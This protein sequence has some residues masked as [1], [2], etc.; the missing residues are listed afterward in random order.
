MERLFPDRIDGMLGLL[1]HHWER[2]QET[3]R[4]VACLLRAGDFASIVYAHQEAIKFYERALV[5]LQ[6]TDERDRT[7]PYTSQTGADLSRC[8]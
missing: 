6:Q 2:A 8:I 5:L 4:A 3:E 7:S 1:A